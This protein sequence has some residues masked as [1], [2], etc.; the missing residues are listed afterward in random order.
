M[1]LHGRT[2]LA[3]HAETVFNAAARMQGHD[4][5]TPLTRTGFAQAEAMGVALRNW[6]GTPQS[7]TLW[8]SDAGRT[9]QTLAVV[10]EHIGADW[11]QTRID[12][13]LREIDV[14]TW[15]GRG[16]ADI[17]QEI[18]PFVDTEAGLF[19]VTP[20]EGESY[21]DVAARLRD[22]IA[23]LGQ[24]H[25]DRLILTHGMTLR[26]LRGLLL[27]NPVDARFGVPLAPMTPQGSLMMIGAGEEKIIY[28]P[29]SANMRT[30]DLTP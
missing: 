19:T 1:A 9:L 11:H 12:P 14:G 18:G 24:D 8:S 17:H 15:V 30:E 27:D 20:P 13:R 23:E 4:A 22:W 28:N 16:Y 3:R 29:K 25:N 2:F 21:A 26:I 7:L 6:L 5:H 10:A